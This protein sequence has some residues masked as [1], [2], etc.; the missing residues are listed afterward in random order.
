MRYPSKHAD[1]VR[2]VMSEDADDVT[3]IIIIM[4]KHADD[5]TDVMSEHA[6]T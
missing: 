5:V 2:D 4:S 1:A 6:A 3:L